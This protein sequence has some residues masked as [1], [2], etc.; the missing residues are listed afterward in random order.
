MKNPKSFE[1]VSNTKIHR[2]NKTHHNRSLVEAEDR[3]DDDGALVGLDFVHIDRL[4]VGVQLALLL[5]F[6]KAHERLLA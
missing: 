5:R 2:R 6:A 1:K 3:V 4:A